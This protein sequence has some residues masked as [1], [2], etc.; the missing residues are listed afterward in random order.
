[1]SELQWLLT[2]MFIV[3]LCLAG[4]DALQNKAI[5]DDVCKTGKLTYIYNDNEYSCGD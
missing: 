1:M 5:K 4:C 2:I 3:A